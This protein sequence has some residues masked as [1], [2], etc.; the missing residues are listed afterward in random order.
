MTARAVSINHWI[1]YMHVAWVFPHLRFDLWVAVGN[2]GSEW[3]V[4]LTGGWA[5]GPLRPVRQ[6]P[7]FHVSIIVST[8]ANGVESSDTSLSSLRICQTQ[9]NFTNKTYSLKFLFLQ[10]PWFGTD[11]RKS[12]WSVQREKGWIRQEMGKHDHIAALFHKRTRRES[13]RIPPEHEG[14]TSHLSPGL[15]SGFYAVRHEIAALSSPEVE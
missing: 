9:L 10:V 3:N 11:I 6:Q 2:D 8:R 4:T 5:I 15:L 14:S 7:S 13:N 1:P 12:K